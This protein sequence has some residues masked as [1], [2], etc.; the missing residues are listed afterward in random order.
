MVLDP[1]MFGAAKPPEVPPP[2]SVMQPPP[3]ND[4]FGDFGGGGGGGGGGGDDFGSFGMDLSGIWNSLLVQPTGEQHPAD[5]VELRRDGDRYYVI[6]PPGKEARDENDYF[7]FDG[8]M[9]VH[10]KGIKIFLQDNGE[11]KADLSTIPDIPAEHR[12][13]I[14]EIIM[15]RE[16]ADQT[17]AKKAE[18]ERKK[19]EEEARIAAEKARVAAEAAARQ[20]AAQRKRSVA[21]GLIVVSVLAVGFAMVVMSS[22]DPSPASV[23][24]PNDGPLVTK[25]PSVACLHSSSGKP[26][27]RRPSGGGQGGGGQA[28]EPGG[29]GA[30][31]GAAG[32]GLHAPPVLLLG[33]ERLRRKCRSRL[34]SRRCWMQRACCTPRWQFRD[35]GY[36][37]AMSAPQINRH[38]RMIACDLGEDAVHRPGEQPFTLCNPSVIDS[39]DGSF[40]LW[41]DC[42]SF[43]H[44]M[45]RLRRA[46]SISLRYY[47]VHGVEHECRDAEANYCS[48]SHHRWC[49]PLIVRRRPYGYCASRRIPCEPRAL[50]PAGGLCHRA[51]S[52]IIYLYIRVENQP[53][54]AQSSQPPMTHLH[55]VHLLA[56]ALR[57]VFLR[58]CWRR[59]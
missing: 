53:I 45:V 59:R 20:A 1:G 26:R 38:V 21:L 8:T 10:Q 39:S 42:M 17:A 2:Q 11:F 33:D 57:P 31:G 55:L 15:R 40:S 35:N 12:A 3:S 36:G 7:D 27:R 50:R 52:V 30:G 6:R 44:L 5:R 9:G 41:D 47:D 25:S 14:G 4:G 46:E 23:A 54:N 18:E 19:A 56:C 48:M 51:H 13:E 29:G 32:G 43:P 22:G 34:E 37:R 16:T 24:K 49:A 28:A 58:C